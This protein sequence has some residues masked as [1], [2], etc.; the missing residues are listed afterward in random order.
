MAKL[1]CAPDVKSAGLVRHVSLGASVAA[2][3]P[4][5]TVYSAA[6]GEL[7][8]ALDYARANPDIFGIET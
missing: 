3:E 7:Q 5:M 4:L 8:Y 2:G 1:A 6:E